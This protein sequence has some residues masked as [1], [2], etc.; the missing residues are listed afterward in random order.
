MYLAFM[1]FFL[2]TDDHR[3]TET[4][5]VKR[6]NCLTGAADYTGRKSTC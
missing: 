6:R 4:Q 2:R 1:S 5:R 3:G